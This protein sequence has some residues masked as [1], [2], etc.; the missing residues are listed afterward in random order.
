MTRSFRFSGWLLIF[1]VSSLY[2]LPQEGIIY[3]EDDTNRFLL[4]PAGKL[5]PA[6]LEGLVDAL[7]GTHVRVLSICCCAQRTNFNSSAWEPYWE[8][9]DPNSDN[10]QPFLGICRKMNAKPAVSGS[11]ICLRYSRLEP[12]P[13]SA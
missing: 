1:A 10:S 11:P 8:G 12:I 3:N 4:A 6:D 9:F 13:T 2:A 7:A 5:T